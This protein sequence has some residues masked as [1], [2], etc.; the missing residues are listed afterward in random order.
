MIQRQRN[1]IGG[2]LMVE[3][4]KTS[5]ILLALLTV[6]GCGS[7]SGG[8]SG[9]GSFNTS[10]SGNKS[11][12]SLSDGEK[13]QLCKDVDAFFKTA[14]VVSAQC[15]VSG[16]TAALVAGIDPNAT[17][18]TLQTSCSQ[19]VTACMSGTADAGSID[20]CAAE[21]FPTT[22][23][24]SVSDLSACLQ[25]F[26][27][28]SDDVPSCNTITRALLKADGGVGASPSGMPGTNTCDTLSTKCPAFFSQNT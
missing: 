20:M 25:D 19:A 24:A 28:L 14:A 17:D 15:K 9:G 8:G 1:F 22:C 13:A 27:K 2:L 3:G 4:I 21:K 10:V 11:L 6:L 18:A 5:G 12:S 7:S 16:F 26:A 23:T